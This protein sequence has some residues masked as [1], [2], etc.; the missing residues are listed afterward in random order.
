ME[1][2]NAAMEMSVGTLV[3]IVLLMA[4][5]GLGLVLIS[6]VFTGST[7]SVDL[8][9]DKVMG[10]INNLFSDSNANVVVKLGADRKAKIKRGS[11]DFGIAIGAQLPEGGSV[12]SRDTMK[13]TLS[14]RSEQGDCVSN[15]AV[16]EEG[17]KA[18][19]RQAPGTAQAPGTEYDFDEYESS[20]LY[21]RIAF[22]VPKT[23]IRCSQKILVDV[24]MKDGTAVGGTFF[25]IEIT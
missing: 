9:N 14:L 18:M 1:N 6:K 22:D 2:K 12:T 17:F 8:I 25:K 3:T 7:D 19:M 20:N 10:E 23:A 11:D 13:Y 15:N 21:A 24:K 16:N 5:L 4:V